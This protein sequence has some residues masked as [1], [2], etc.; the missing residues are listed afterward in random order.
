[1]VVVSL[2]QFA[3]GVR[4]KKSIPI[5]ETDT[6]T[7]SIGLFIMYLYI[8][9]CIDDD[10]CTYIQPSPQELNVTEIKQGKQKDVPNAQ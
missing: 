8:H 6:K 5:C 9:V 4:T 7:V 2:Y 1:M 10:V 3:F